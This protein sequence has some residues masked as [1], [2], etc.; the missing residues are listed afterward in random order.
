MPEDR[1]RVVELFR[2]VFGD[3]FAATARMTWKWKYEMNP[4]LPPLTPRM[5]ITEHRGEAVASFGVVAARIAIQGRAVPMVW[6]VDFCAHPKHRGRGPRMIK[7]VM[8]QQ[9]DNVVQMG[10]PVGRAYE[11]EKRIGCLDLASTVTLKRLLR[12][13]RAA[14]IRKGAAAALAIGTAGKIASA[15]LLILRGFAPG[16][17][18]VGLAPKFDARFDALWQRVGQDF[19]VILV[20]DSAYLTWRFSKCPHKTYETVTVDRGGDLAGYATLRVEESRGLKQALVVDLLAGRNDRRALRALL[21]AVDAYGRAQR[22]DV[23]SCTVSRDQKWLRDALRRCGYLA[24]NPGLPV[25]MGTGGLYR[26]VLPTL[27]DWYLTRADS[28]VEMGGDV[29]P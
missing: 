1:D 20:R 19:A 13:Y 16:G 18:N 6:G 4:A 3:A 17:F 29:T 21:D 26:D 10:T 14:Y 5:F 12:P 7:Y 2:A 27:R 23:I 15:G 22:I 8:D 28:D 11:L 9:C 24:A 25:V